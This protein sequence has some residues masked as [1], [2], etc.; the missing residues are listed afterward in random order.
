MNQAP[1]LLFSWK[2]RL[3]LVVFCAAILGAIGYFWQA[4]FD[5]ETIIGSADNIHPLYFLLAMSVLPAVGFP[6]SAFYLLAGIAYHWSLAWLLCILSLALNVSLSYFLTRYFLRDPIAAML[7]KRGYRIPQISETNQLRMTF[8]LRA[9][10]GPPYPLQ[11]YLL[12]L[13]EIKFPL[14]FAVSVSVQSVFAL[15]MISISNE[16]IKNGNLIKASIFACVIGLLFLFK[17][18]LSAKRKSS[19]PT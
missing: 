13:A 19:T 14:Y 16:I 6:I 15:G 2:N 17:Q 8:L 10:P 18:R 12:S 3:K 1:T 7:Q 9:V 11:N 4:G 5:I